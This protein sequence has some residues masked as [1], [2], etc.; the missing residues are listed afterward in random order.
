MILLEVLR[1]Y[2]GVSAIY[3]MLINKTRVA[4]INL[5]EGTLIILPILAL[6]HDQETWG[7]DALEF[8]PER[9]SNGVSK[10]T[11]KGQVS[12][13]PFGG[14][15]RICIGQN[16]AMLEAKIALVMILQRFSFGLSPSYSHAP[17]S[18]ITLQPQF[19]AHLILQRIKTDS[20]I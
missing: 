10:A 3:R 18:A 4:G 5:P 9:F 11:S 16:F 2:P 14:G 19:G 12:Y 7:D 13:F 17:Q 20:I 1:L 15:P 6:H 8:N